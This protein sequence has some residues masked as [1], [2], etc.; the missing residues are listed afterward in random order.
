MLKVIISKES[1][2]SVT[3]AGMNAANSIS[4]TLS[5]VVEVFNPSKAEIIKKSVV[6]MKAEDLWDA[7]PQKDLTVGTKLV[8]NGDTVEV[9]YNHETIVDIINTVGR[10][11][12]N[13][14]NPA[15]TFGVAMLQTKVAAEQYKDEIT[16]VM[17]KASQKLDSNETD[18]KED[19][20]VS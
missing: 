13:L 1:F 18:T 2:V 16:A 5:R 19:I 7:L 17:T 15:M 8:R 3:A 20:K 9:E 10:F 6:D 4:N 11:Y 12:T 14:I